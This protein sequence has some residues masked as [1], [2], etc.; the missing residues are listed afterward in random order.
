MLNHFKHYKCYDWTCSHNPASAIIPSKRRLLLNL[1]LLTI[2]IYIIIYQTTTYILQ[3][4]TNTGHF[5]FECSKYEANREELYILLNIKI[6]DYSSHLAL[7]NYLFTN[8]PN[9]A[10]NCFISVK[11]PYGVPSQIAAETLNKVIFCVN[12]E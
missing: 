5:L 3:V 10:V 9:I 1:N 6:N 4:Q 2:I 12:N 11:T 7:L 8:L